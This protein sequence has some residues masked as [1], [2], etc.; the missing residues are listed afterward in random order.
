MARKPVDV[1][2]AELA[3]LQ[4]LWGREAATVRDLA[5]TLYPRETASDL[6]TVQKL[7]KRLE[8]KGCVERDR[9]QWPHMFR[10]RLNRE[11]LIG[12]RLRDTANDLCNGALTPLLTHLVRTSPLS[13]EER[14]ELR[15]LL[16]QFETSSS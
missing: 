12:R 14:Q 3:I 7:L 2:D 10:P 6:A 9:Q 1:T 11:E 5:Q 8:E 16:D 15:E 4:V 13:A